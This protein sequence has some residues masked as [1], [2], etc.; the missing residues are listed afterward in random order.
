MKK[1]VVLVVARSHS[2]VGFAPERQLLFEFSALIRLKP[3]DWA[4]FG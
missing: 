3:V 4:C 1:V 2:R